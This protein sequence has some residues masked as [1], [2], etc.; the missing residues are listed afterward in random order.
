MFVRCAD[1]S[2]VNKD[3]VFLVDSS[4]KPSYNES[5]FYILSFLQDVVDK[6]RVTKRTSRVAV[7]RYSDTAN[8][9]IALN[10]VDQVGLPWSEIFDI[11]WIFSIFSKL[12]FF[13]GPS[14]NKLFNHVYPDNS[15]FLITSHSCIVHIA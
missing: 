2:A 9:S 15:V 14:S 10:Y 3:V 8:L 7:V 5:W 4:W 6:L 12:Y 11:Y 1:C 13:I